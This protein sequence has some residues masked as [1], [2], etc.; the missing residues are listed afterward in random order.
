MYARKRSSRI[1]DA[2]GAAAGVAVLPMP[3]AHTTSPAKCV[4]AVVFR[5]SRSDAPNAAAH[6]G[7][8]V[9]FRRRGRE[10]GQNLLRGRRPLHVGLVHDDAKRHRAPELEVHAVEQL[11]RHRPL[12]RLVRIHHINNSVGGVGAVSVFN[13]H[14]VLGRRRER[15]RAFARRVDTRVRFSNRRDFGALEVSRG[16]SDFG[17]V[18]RPRV[19]IVFGEYGWVSRSMEEKNASAAMRTTMGTNRESERDWVSDEDDEEEENIG[20]RG[21]GMY[22]NV[23]ARR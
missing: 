5:K 14:V 21:G 3:G 16:P 19:R 7:A 22:R 9:D 8:G 6:G 17:A 15:F 13:N 10:L 18:C 1:S 20:G 23:R 11:D 2:A 4:P 12:R